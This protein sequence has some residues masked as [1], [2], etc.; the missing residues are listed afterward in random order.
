MKMTVAHTGSNTMNII[1]STM[2]IITTSIMNITMTSIMNI[3]MTSIMS[4]ITSTT[5]NMGA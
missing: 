5:T 3:T 2:N 4:I 1:M